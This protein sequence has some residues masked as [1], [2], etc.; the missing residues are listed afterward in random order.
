MNTHIMW[1]V[2]TLIAVSLAVAPCVS[3]QDILY[4]KPKNSSESP[5]DCP[6]M[7]CLTLERYTEQ[8]NIYFTSGVAFIFLEGSH[9]FHHSLELINISDLS[10]QGPE[11]SS[12]KATIV[13]TAYITLINA[14]NL[15][16]E[17]LR[18]MR[19]D[20]ANIEIKGS[21]DILI[22]SSVFQS[23]NLTDYTALVLE[24]SIITIQNCLFEGNRVKGSGG[25][26]IVDRQTQLILVGNNFIRNSA[27]T[28]CAIL[29][30]QSSL[31]LQGLPNI[32]SRNFC[33]GQGGT[34]FCSECTI[35]ITHKVLFENNACTSHERTPILYYR[36]A[37]AIYVTTGR[38]YISGSVIFYQ[39]KA[40][41]A[42]II[43]LKCFHAVIT[44]KGMLFR[45]NIGR[46]MN[47]ISSLSVFYENSTHPCA[48]Y[49]RNIKS[50]NPLLDW[51]NLISA[52]LV[53]NSASIHMFDVK[54][55][56][57][58]NLTIIGGYYYVSGVGIAS[59]SGIKFDGVSSF[60]WNY[61][62]FDISESEV[63]FSGY[64]KIINCLSHGMVVSKSSTVTFKGHSSF[65]NNKGERGGAIKSLISNITFSGT[66]LFTNNQ[67][68]GDL[69]GG[70]LYALGT[71]IR[72]KGDVEFSFNSGRNGG[73]MNFEESSLKLEP[74]T[75]L[76]T[77]HN[78]ATDYG[79]AMYHK[80]IITTTQCKFK[81]IE[82][83]DIQPHKL[84]Y[85][86]IE[87]EINQ[88][89]LDSFGMHSFY[90]SAGKDGSYIYGGLLDKCEFKDE[91][92]SLNAHVFLYFA[93]QYVHITSNNSLTNVIASEPYQLCFCNDLSFDTI[94]NEMEISTHRG[95]EFTV[96][97][98]AIGQNNGIVPTRLTAITSNNGRLKDNHQGQ[99][100]IPR[101]CS[102]LNFSVYSNDSHMT[103]TLYPDGPC[104]DIGTARVILNITILPCPDAFTQDGEQC[105]CEE[106]LQQYDANCTIDKTILI[107]RNAGSKFWMDALY[108]NGSYQGLILYR[109]CPTE[110]CTNEG[111]D[112]TLE[113]LDI[114]CD[115][116][117]TGMLCGACAT[118][119]S[120]LLG[121]SRCGICSHH[122][123][124]LLIPFA[125]AGIVLVV[126]LSFLR[127]TVATG[128]INSFIF[129]ANFVQVNKM[130]FLPTN[131]VNILTLFIAWLNLDLGIET[132]F[133]AGLDAYI[134][135]W[136]QFA[137]PLYVWFLIGLIIF[138]SRY[139]I[140][141]SKLLGR[142]PIAV[143]ATLILMSYTKVLK[144]II[145]TF[146]SV[147]LDYPGG[148]LV[149]VWL[150]DASVPFLRSKHLALS[151]VISL[152]L[153]LFFL[154]YTTFLLMGPR[155][156][157]ISH[158]RCY[159][160]LRR[161]KPLLDSYYAPYKPTTRYWIG[162]RLLIRCA[163]YIV[164]SYN[165][166]GN[167]NNSLFAIII[168]FTAIG[169]IP[170]Y[171]GRIYRNF[172]IDIIEGSV[173]LN[174]IVL[175]AAVLA[176]INKIALVYTLIGIVFV[177]MLGT[178]VY[179]F[180]TIYIA[181]T[182]TWLKIKAMALAFR[183][184]PKNATETEAPVDAP[185]E[186]GPLKVV[187]KTIVEL[188]EPLLEADNN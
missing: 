120:L 109:S 104:H 169:L 140:T 168:T 179:Q 135:T 34:I 65:Q 82:D 28:G 91:I 53:N 94:S 12:S 67:A 151:V 134:Q 3:T 90:D 147:K 14:T 167:T 133:Y 155:I 129:Y 119:Y 93:R 18:F 16:I 52:K 127:L 154:P 71:E 6:S 92:D 128:M 44:G 49:R 88:E 46:M 160:I 23:S 30:I 81:Y 42:N 175:S 27:T 142:N 138:G 102:H 87:F 156:Y 9:E 32:F 51:E 106:R 131:R 35:N 164:F 37:A 4:V 64:T 184:K 100:N 144:I 95:Q 170:W 66:T 57:F 31:I 36:R 107:K 50:F 11:N 185:A 98:L 118:N 5:I 54:R 29:A 40:P 180:H 38:L 26:L 7:P 124:A 43:Y 63:A 62:A 171:C 176:G 182:A 13:C 69:G 146:S 132:C 162:F 78:T 77:S 56:I 1:S 148:R 79:G 157:R 139:S 145:E 183:Q 121:S 130:T 116:N 159:F 2:V 80:D 150:K 21:K 74:D 86:F 76:I 8:S 143:L 85:C 17:R 61:K 45:D 173:H 122:Y 111:V 110:Y 178:I 55:M 112:I 47:M 41:D 136:L 117:R 99:R 137:F 22:S 84:R 172:Y 24:S 126:F 58:Q 68:T 153:A 105:V 174:F 163:L 48:V 113:T 10:L 73:A 177:T 96:S 72:L 70:A 186:A 89:N 161:I 39:N 75:V 19:Y 141:I 103:I 25:A 123:L 15:R 108:I 188:R 181:K 149:T 187:S 101:L 60:F 59:C 83:A 114:Q 33:V 152:V 165:S 20:E 125:I 97:I 166:L 158:K 115:Y